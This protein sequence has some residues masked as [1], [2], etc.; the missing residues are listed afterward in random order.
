MNNPFLID[1]KTIFSGF[2]GK[3]CWVN[4]MVS[5]IPENSGRAILITQ[6]LLVSNADRF[7]GINMTESR[8]NGTTWNSLRPID[9]M[10]NRP[11]GNR[12][13]CIGGMTAYY[14]PEIKKILSLGCDV[15]YTSDHQIDPSYQRSIV[16]AFF[17]PR[18]D[19]WTDLRKLELPF[20]LNSHSSVLA[21]NS[22]FEILNN[23]DL[24]IPAYVK[25]AN[26][27]DPFGG[28]YSTV[29][30]HCKPEGEI[31]NCHGHGKILAMDI[32]RGLFEPSLVF[33]RGRYL[34]T[35]RNDQSGY[36][37]TGETPFDFGPP[38]K[39]TFDDGQWLGNY[40]T[41]Q[42]WLTLGDDLYLVYTRKGLNNDHIFRHRAPLMIGK[43]DTDTMTII[44]KTE[45]IV[46]PE[47]G[48]R[49]GNFGVT[50]ISAKESWITVA[51]WMQ[52]DGCERYG[53]DNSIY[54][55]RVIAK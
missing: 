25:T 22:Q 4:P 55:A 38:K 12:E 14:L 29:I 44:R 26:S 10:Q 42:H 45:R 31:L 1:V 36:V 37:S 40:N 54:I 20:P 13:L 48:A 43:V 39:W 33:Y 16:Y 28:R 35:L 34:L 2:D 6:K 46:I 7:F 21:V 19:C 8:D 49:L 30:L 15:A 11:A 50:R 9:G 53:C 5:F 24:A 32:E 18:N 41:Q 51:E 3:T 17:D 52:P 23:G 27:H 47:R